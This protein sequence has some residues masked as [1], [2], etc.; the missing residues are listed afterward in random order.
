ML[1]EFLNRIVALAIDANTARFVSH[2]SLPD[3][4]FLNKPDGSV[5]KVEVPP[6]TRNHELLGLQDIVAI[7]KD[8]VI[9]ASPEVW[10]S[11][12]CVAIILNRLKRR[13]VVTCG[14]AHTEQFTTLLDLLSPTQL[15]PRQA[16]K[17]LRFDLH[18]ANTE[19]VVQA[20][21]RV[22]FL[23]TSEGKSSVEHGK[24][25]LG[26]SVEA[27]VQQ[28]D[29]IPDRFTMTVPIWLGFPYTATVACGCY[30]DLETERVE[31][32]VLA[33]EIGRAVERA[34]KELAD[35]IVKLVDAPV[36][37]GSA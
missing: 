26:R 32:R 28:A 34:V 7:V 6:P 25:S 14:L 35:G 29:S 36:F 30:L 4:V 21:R 2:E 3:S 9:S 10:V 22:D 8:E 33:D 15:Q 31:L 37:M 23:R 12:T 5:E 1:A 13:E 18:G 20:L 24:E 11:N 17:L 19:G 16:I 27:A